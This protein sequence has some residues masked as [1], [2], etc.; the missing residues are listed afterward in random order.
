MT[1]L[2]DCWQSLPGILA[3]KRVGGVPTVFPA[4]SGDVG[5]EENL[6][7]PVYNMRPMQVRC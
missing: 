5:A 2:L 1:L 3:V 7:Q 6:L 4:E